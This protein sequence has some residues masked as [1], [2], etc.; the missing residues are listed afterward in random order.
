MQN[1]QI[2]V[3]RPK[4]VLLYLGPAENAARL[5]GGCHMNFTWARELCPE[6]AHQGVVVSVWCLY[7]HRPTRRL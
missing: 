3:D 1:G 6:E 7:E 4:L 2:S 5:V